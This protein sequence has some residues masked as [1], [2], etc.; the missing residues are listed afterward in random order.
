MADVFLSYSSKDRAAA[1]RVQAA[2]SRAGIDVFWDQETPPGV[3]W[4]TWIR[5]K[6]SNARAAVVLWSKESIASPNVRHEAIVAR[7]AGKLV[8][9]MIETLAASDFPMG[10]YLV[11]GIQLQDWRNASSGGM[12]RLVT[13]VEARLGR[14]VGAGRAPPKTPY[15]TPVPT[16]AQKQ[17]RMFLGLVVLAIVALAVVGTLA[18]QTFFDQNAKTS[19]PTM[20]GPEASVG[21]TGLGPTCLDGSDPSS[22][23]CANGA[24]PIPPAPALGGGD[25]FAQR[26]IGRWR[27]SDGQPCAA[28]P[29]ITL[30]SGRLIVT[31]PENRF[32]HMIDADAALQLRTTVLEPAEQVGHSY[33]LTPEFMA[34]T[35]IRSFNL[36]V[37]DKT[38]GS[39]NVWTPCEL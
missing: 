24:R 12:A 31:T 25:S 8:P 22:E 16:A 17:A 13:E 29:K 28:G 32:V 19:D 35:D 39:R 7:D 38:E 11:Q 21:P 6:L 10:L 26:V 1:E 37:E 9:V 15:L 18:M 14:G 34:T 27:W 5:G 3:D 36:V 2:L 33:V 4:D 23:T 30:E 20:S